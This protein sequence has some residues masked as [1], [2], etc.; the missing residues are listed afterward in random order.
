MKKY[1]E[2]HTVKQDVYKKIVN[3]FVPS[4]VFVS[5]EQNNAEEVECLVEKGQILEEGE[6]IGEG[7]FSPI[8][9][10]VEDFEFKVMP[11][12]NVNKTVKISLKGKFSYLGKK[13]KEIDY[14]SFTP[15][16]LI[17]H[18]E[19]YGILNTFVTDRPV[20]LSSQLKEI[21][22]H[23]HRLLVV[24]LIDDDP[25]RLT[26]SVLSSQ[27][28]AEIIKA[29]NIAS[30]AINAEGVV[31]T[32]GEKFVKSSEFDQ[33]KL[34][35]F[36]NR[37]ESKLFPLTLPEL[38]CQSVKKNAKDAI[39]KRLSKH[40]LFLDSSTLL[41]LYRC[42]SFDMPVIDRYVMVDGDCLPSTGLLKFAIGT[43]FE[44]IAEHCGGFIK[45]PASIIVNGLVSG[46][47]AGSLNVPLTKYVKS[48]RFNS[49]SKTVSQKQIE[50]V[51]C[52]N[53][54]RIC[55]MGLSP[56][57][58]VRHLMGGVAAPADFIES[59]SF[60]MECGLCN[61]VCPSRIPLLQLIRDFKEES[62]A[63]VIKE[64]KQIASSEKTVEGKI[65][66]KL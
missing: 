58:I 2:I 54:H 56:D 50:C 65:D 47:S 9:G 60:C 55:P 42:V 22:S 23:K 30:Y 18:I 53:C 59:A 29:I 31:I 61:S 62:R 27:F 64:E 34:P 46:F 11:N 49:S 33:I 37:V 13:I 5:L 8:P 20:L 15:E 40:D 7:V 63:K 48:I 25:S 17:K 35:V 43:P 19:E 1:P 36:I 52:G 38:V 10:K 66:E 57:V 44:L 41:E 45:K 16:L 39:F 28:T 51:R 32:T 3:A 4:K 12:G 24:R 14:T 26:D 21:F 6:K